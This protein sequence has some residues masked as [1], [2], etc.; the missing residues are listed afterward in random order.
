MAGNLRAKLASSD[1]LVVNDVNAAAVAKF[2]EEHGTGVDVAGSV[3][4]VAEQ[5]VGLHSSTQSPCTTMNTYL[6]YL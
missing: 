1:K 6:F 4:E 5:S 3:R 2:K